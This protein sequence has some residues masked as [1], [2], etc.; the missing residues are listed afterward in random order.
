M[1][2]DYR[3]EGRFLSGAIA[4][5]HGDGTYAVEVRSRVSESNRAV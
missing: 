1:R 4:R 2:A 3:G 5:D